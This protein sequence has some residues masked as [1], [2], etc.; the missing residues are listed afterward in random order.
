M[1]IDPVHLHQLESLECWQGPIAVEPLRGGITNHNYLVCSGSNRF[2]VRIYADRSVLGIDR[3]NEVA[4]Q[5]AASALGVAPEVVHHEPGVLVSTYIRGRTLEAADFQDPA[6]LARVATLLRSL[7]QGGTEI[8]AEMLDFS[9]FPTI[10]TYAM[11]AL[12]LKAWLPEDLE[13][14]LEDARNLGRQI[15]PFVPVLCHNDMLPAN[16]LA[17]EER[18]WLVDWEYAGMGHPLFDL[19]SVAA[20]GELSESLEVA[21]LRAYRGTL[22][23]RD[24]GELRVLRSMS[25]LRE[26]LWGAIQSVDAGI[27]FDYR[28]YADKNFCAYRETRRRWHE[29]IATGG[30]DR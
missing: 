12:R 24:L 8:A 21:L 17:D 6:L 3:R 20:N 15:G 25:L 29:P 4:C 27:A 30:T 10:R 26:A 23:E 5:R 14:L 2:V 9:V 13:C 7:H 1:K 16:V 22:D 11:T 28:G 19:A 18:I